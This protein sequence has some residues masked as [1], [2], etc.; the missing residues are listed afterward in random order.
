A[1]L[2]FA[3]NDR[4]RVYLSAGRGFETPTFNELSYRADGGAGLAFDLRPAISD[5]LELGFKWRRS[6]GG[7]LEAALFRADTDNELAVARNVGGR[8]SFSN[9][10]SARREG[11]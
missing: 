6:G 3:P 4:T 9:V 2:M 8:S 5:N 7:L 11:V 10:G 1:G